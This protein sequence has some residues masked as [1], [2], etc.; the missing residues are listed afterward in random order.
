MIVVGIMQLIGKLTT[1]ICVINQTY[2]LWLVVRKNGRILQLFFINN[3]G[4]HKKAEWLVFMFKILNK[5]VLTIHGYELRR[6]IISL[7]LYHSYLSSELLR[8][9]TVRWWC[10][11]ITCYCGYSDWSI[12]YWIRLIDRHNAD[13][14]YTIGGCTGLKN[15]FFLQI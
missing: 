4:K 1:S 12:I 3:I 8:C 11:R 14:R 9:W 13:N 7:R 10:A 5:N 2:Q 15:K 6:V